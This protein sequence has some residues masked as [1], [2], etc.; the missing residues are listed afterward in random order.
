[1]IDRSPGE[2][3]EVM[4][5][6]ISCIKSESD[7]A[8]GWS[9]MTRSINAFSLKFEKK[10]K[11]KWRISSDDSDGDALDG[12]SAVIRILVS[13]SYGLVVVVMLIVVRYCDAHV[14][15]SGR[16]RTALHP[17]LLLFTTQDG[18]SA[19]VMLERI[20]VVAGFDH[21]QTTFPSL[22]PPT[23]PVDEQDDQAGS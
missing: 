15:V 9:R 14:V 4:Y 10:R 8:V 16:C 1:M 22:T 5:K 6:K 19:V 17:I 12:P 11:E 3:E 7:W 18:T 20:V 2:K 21:H 13:G 23:P